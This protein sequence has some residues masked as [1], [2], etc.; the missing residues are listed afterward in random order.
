ML[1]ATQ[2]FDGVV[3]C[4]R[5]RTGICDVYRYTENA[6]AWEL[7]RQ[8]QDLGLRGPKGRFQIPE[9]AA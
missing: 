8:L 3:D 2:A 9:A 5:N 1:D 6:D 7:L 4:F